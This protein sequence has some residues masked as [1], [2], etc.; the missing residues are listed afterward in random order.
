MQLEVIRHGNQYVSGEDPDVECPEC[1][2]VT[3]PHLSVG[4]DKDG[5]AVLS[6]DCQNCGAFFIGKTDVSLKANQP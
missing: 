5:K 6:Y 2:V 4:A 3:E 1:N